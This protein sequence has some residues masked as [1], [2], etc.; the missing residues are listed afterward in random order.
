MTEEHLFIGG[1]LDGQRIELLAGQA[2]FDGVATPRPD[3][4][5]EF[6]TLDNAKPC[7]AEFKTVRYYRQIVNVPNTPH[8]YFLMTL[9]G[10]LEPEHI[11]QVLI[12]GYRRVED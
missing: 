3:L 1:P 6:A 9:T 5:K 11:M 8:R 7:D 2:T 12:R 10:N 4:V